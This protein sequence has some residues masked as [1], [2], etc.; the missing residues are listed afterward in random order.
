MGLKLRLIGTGVRL[1]QICSLNLRRLT[2]LASIETRIIVTTFGILREMIY[3]VMTQLSYR[4]S[5]LR[6]WFE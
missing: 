5:L 1:R 3:I 6:N 2:V 4:E